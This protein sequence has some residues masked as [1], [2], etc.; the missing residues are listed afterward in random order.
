MEKPEMHHLPRLSREF[1]QAFAVV[2][3]TITFEDRATGWL[4]ELFHQYFRELLLHA[5]ARE[6]LFCPTYCLMP[7]HIHLLWMG[8]KVSTDQIV[9]MKFLRQQL[10]AEVAKRSRPEKLIKLQKQSHDHVLRE[11]DRKR[12]A[13]A[14]ICFY[15]LANPAENKLVVKAEDW[16]FHGAIVPGYPTFHPLEDNFWPLFWE[17]YERQREPTPDDVS[18][19]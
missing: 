8:M 13:F 12:N 10:N 4:D 17:Q 16:P 6:G 2:H 3:W 18:G 14:K 19:S 11:Q 5:A 9:A 15:V 7:D 1:Y